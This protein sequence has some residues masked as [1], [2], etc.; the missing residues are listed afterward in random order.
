MF[1]FSP[2]PLSIYSEL[3][4]CVP[5]GGPASRSCSQGALPA[6]PLGSS[7]GCFQVFWGPF[8]AAAGAAPPNI[9]PLGAWGGESEALE[10]FLGKG[11]KPDPFG[12][13]QCGLGTC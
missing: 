13:L 6:C 5:C 12:E 8:T 3:S 4:G 2:P 10:L 1:F 11:L 7:F 9:H